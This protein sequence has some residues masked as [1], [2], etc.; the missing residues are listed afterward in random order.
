M[1]SNTR[2]WAAAS[3]ITVAG[4]IIVCSRRTCEGDCYDLTNFSSIPAHTIS[5][6]W[7]AALVAGTG[8]KNSD[9]D[10]DAS[11]AASSLPLYKI[12][13]KATMMLDICIVA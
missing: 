9:G 7:H 5:I 6:H 2:E 3:H 8:L 4:K 11:E 10:S 13:V 12:Q 1:A